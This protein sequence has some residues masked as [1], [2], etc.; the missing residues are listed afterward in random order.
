MPYKR[1]SDNE[2]TNITDSRHPCRL[3]ISDRNVSGMGDIFFYTG[4]LQDKRLPPSEMPITCRSYEEYLEALD[5]PKVNPDFQY[6][7]V[8]IGIGGFIPHL[9]QTFNGK[10]KH[11]PIAIDPAEYNVMK[12]LLEFALTRKDLR[13]ESA[14][15]MRTFLGRIEII[16]DPSKVRLFNMKLGEAVRT[17]PELR[18]CAD[19]VIDVAGPRIY[20]DTELTANDQIGRVSLKEMKRRISSLEKKLRK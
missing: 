3:V 11:K 7:E 4:A 19:V 1:F 16:T 8:G 14:E 13:P 18:H 17:H 5:H 6:A 12:R 20:I 9:I 15:K 10:I 2:G